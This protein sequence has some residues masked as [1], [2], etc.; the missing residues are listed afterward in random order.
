MILIVSTCADRL[1]EYEFVKP[2]ARILGRYDSYEVVSY[3]EVGPGVVERYDK[4]VISGTAL[5]DFDYLRYVDR[6]SWVKEFEGPVLGICAG[7]QLVSLVFRVGLRDKLVI[8]VREVEVVRENR[9][10]KTGKLK[11]YFVTSKL[12]A[13]SSA[14]EV[15]GVSE[16]ENVFFKVKDREVY[17]LAFHPEVYNEEILASFARL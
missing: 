5:K 17:A 15:L 4:V 3:R 11:A 10:A 9:L 6:F 12:P 1:S 7:L 2:L 14:V 16:G 13:P 8:G